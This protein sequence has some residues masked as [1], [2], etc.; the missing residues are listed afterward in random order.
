MD[1]DALRTRFMTVFV[2]SGSVV[3]LAHQFHKRLVSNFMKKIEFELGSGPNQTKKKVRFS[4]E[5]LKVLSTNKQN[6]KKLSSNVTMAAAAMDRSCD[7][8]KCRKTMPLNWQIMYK[9]IIDYKNS[10]SVP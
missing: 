10:I 9:G 4:C 7:N 1:S 5:A 8:K 6:S 2:V 3:I